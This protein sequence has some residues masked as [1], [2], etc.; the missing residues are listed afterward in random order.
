MI[1]NG[2]LEVLE[3]P[4]HSRAA[5]LRCPGHVNELTGR[6]VKLYLTAGMH[7]LEKLMSRESTV[8][9]CVKNARKRVMLMRLPV[10]AVASLFKKI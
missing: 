9:Q 7:F 1:N 4:S 10:A 2:F 6:V 3:A 5:P 8:T